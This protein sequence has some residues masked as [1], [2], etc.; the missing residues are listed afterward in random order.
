MPRLKLGQVPGLRRHRS[1]QRAV[2][3]LNYKDYYLGPWLDYEPSPSK[4][5]VKAYERL[6]AEWLARGRR[7]ERPVPIVGAEQ[8]LSA[9]VSVEELCERFLEHARRHYSRDDGTSTSETT[10]FH[11]AFRLLREVYGELGVAD[12][13]PLKLK[14]VREKM[15][16]GGLSRKVIN[17]WSARIV[18]AFKWGVSE[19]LVPVQVHQALATVKGLQRGRTNAV[20]KAPVEPVSDEHVQK[21]LPF[22]LPEVAAMVMVQRYTGMRPGKSVRCG[23]ARS[24]AAARSGSTS[25]ADTR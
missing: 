8:S 23:V 18:R 16:A 21:T 15:I 25:P 13:S 5:V 11:Y 7:P 1:T 12:F 4:E 20:E 2:V 3:T 22:L 17:D 24:T 19:E 10:C 6:I 14:A 9:G